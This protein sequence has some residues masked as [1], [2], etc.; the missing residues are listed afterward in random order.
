MKLKGG[1]KYREGRGQRE[2]MRERRER[3]N[4]VS[5]KAFNMTPAP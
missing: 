4:I 3:K 2:G 1:Y 5:N